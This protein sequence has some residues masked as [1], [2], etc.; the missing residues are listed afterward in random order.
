ML[1]LFLSLLPLKKP[2]KKSEEKIEAKKSM[3]VKYRVF[4]SRSPHEDLGMF[5]LKERTN[6]RKGKDQLFY[7]F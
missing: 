6:E 7:I 5:V 4:G 3:T 1:S 2:T